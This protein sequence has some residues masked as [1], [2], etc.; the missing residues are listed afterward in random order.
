MGDD[1]IRPFRSEARLADGKAFTD[2]QHLAACDQR[3]GL[4]FLQK[5]DREIGGHRKGHFTNRAQKRH[6]NRNIG[7][8]H[9]RRSGNGASGPELAFMIGHTHAA[10]AHANLGHREDFAMAKQLGEVP[11][12]KCVDFGQCES[13]IGHKRRVKRGMDFKQEHTALITILTFSASGATVCG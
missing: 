10:S 2:L 8:L 7:K 1:I 3:A 9:H 4:G 6:P 11:P 12:Q 13:G 5:I